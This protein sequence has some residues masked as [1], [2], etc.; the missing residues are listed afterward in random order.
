MS[1]QIE[2]AAGEEGL[3]AEHDDPTELGDAAQ[4]KGEGF[5]GKGVDL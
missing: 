5:I 1:E 3:E 2:A 4:K